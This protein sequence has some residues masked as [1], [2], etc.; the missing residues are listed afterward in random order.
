MSAPEELSTTVEVEAQ[1]GTHQAGSAPDIMDVSTSMMVLTWITFGIVAAV[2]YKI[3]WQPILNS[4]AERE[5][6]IRR[7]LAEAD[8]A[9]AGA[10]ETE[11]RIRKALAE[12]ESRAREIV[13]D[14][15][16]AAAR[17]SEQAAAETRQRTA[18]MV[19]QS[20][21]DIEAAIGKARTDL[22][23]ET[24]EL[25]VAAAARILGRELDAGSDAQLVER[26]A[27]EL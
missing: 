25:A 6:R 10:A 11:E 23:R 20:R 14:A 8:R 16:S 2:L 22:R 13:D 9:R 15:R 1:P 17:L 3:A 12:S 4:V 21:R 5:K 26:L 7:S 19:A 27:R 24:A 18:E